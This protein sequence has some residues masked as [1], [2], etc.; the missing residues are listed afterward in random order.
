MQEVKV[1]IAVVV[2]IGVE[3]GLDAPRCWKASYLVG[4]GGAGV[5]VLGVNWSCAPKRSPVKRFV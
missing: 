2:A 3:W 4:S 5:C 1:L